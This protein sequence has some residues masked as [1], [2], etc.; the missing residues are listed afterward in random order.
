[1]FW[2][3]LCLFTIGLFLFCSPASA[4]HTPEVINSF[5]SYIEVASSSKLSVIE[6]ITVTAA[7]LEMRHG[8]YR[9]FPTRY[10]DETGKSHYSSFNVLRVMRDGSDIPYSVKTQ[11]NGKRVYM[12]DTNIDLAP[13]KHKYL[14]AY[15]TTN[16]LKFFP[17]HDELYWNVTG[18]GWSFPINRATANITLPHG[19]KM[20]QQSGYVGP[21]GSKE[22]SYKYTKGANGDYIF[23][24]ARPLDI[25]EGLTIAIS[26][27]KG[28]VEQPKPSPKDFLQAYAHLYFYV[29]VGIL[30][31]YYF[32]T[33]LI[34][35]RD[36]PLGPVIPLFAPPNKL[37]PAEVGSIFY[38]TSLADRDGR[39]FSA[40]MVSLAVKGHIKI[41]RM[42]DTYYLNKTSGNATPLG[43]EE[44]IIMSLF[45]ADESL[46]I[47]KKHSSALED[48]FTNF[49]TLL[50]AKFKKPYLVG[51]YLFSAI[52]II[53]NLI[54]FAPFF[55]DLFPVD[56]TFMSEPILVCVV[57]MHVIFARL[58]K[59]SSP[60]GQ[61][62]VD[63]IAG[64]RIYLDIGEKERLEK[65][66]PPE[67]TPE[68]F[69]KFLPYAI[70]LGVQN[71]WG[72]QFSSRIAQGLYQD[73]QPTWYAGHD[74]H[75][76]D[77][78]GFCSSF[79]ST[80][81]AGVAASSSGVGGGGC[82]GGGGGGGGGGGF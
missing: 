17:D 78:D 45:G 14:L 27:P 75:M 8:I 10:I 16:Q 37:T 13:G 6:Q 26:W 61:K 52:G 38:N 68:L 35:G 9:D 70:A 43:P 19:A 5:D 77:F 21:Q 39:L 62:L 42:D 57:A 20:L 40:A 48:T 34:V 58:L 25:R 49:S 22:Q 73:Y 31:L 80:V 60:T 30:L 32:I 56:M 71:E 63:Q 33:W 65:L 44:H 23:T 54:L 50:K 11:S 29:A 12:G 66:T 69:E 76:N 79:T 72:Q 53:L 24:A 28:L 59:K 7:N 51:N 74:F 55:I 81:N 82:S 67:L 47:E 4:A 2:Q 15:E 36:K 64:F 18:N 41:G 1:M 46:V 3:Q